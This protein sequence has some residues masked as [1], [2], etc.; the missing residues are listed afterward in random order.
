MASYI[1]LQG[2]ELSRHQSYRITPYETFPLYE[3]KMLACHTGK[4][5]YWIIT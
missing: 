5:I 2:Y 3:A 4:H 1:D